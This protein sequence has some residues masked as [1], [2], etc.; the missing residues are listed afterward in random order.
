MGNFTVTVNFAY[1]GKTNG[2]D[3]RM[4]RCKNEEENKTYRTTNEAMN[5]MDQDMP[6]QR[7][8]IAHRF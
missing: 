8:D 6:K 1:P 7:P 3:T 5:W 4:N 2:L